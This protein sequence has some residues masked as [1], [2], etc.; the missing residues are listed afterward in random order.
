MISS[1]PN[2]PPASSLTDLVTHY[3][4][5]LSSSLTTLAPLKTRSVSFTHTAPWFTPHL[6]QLKAT[7]CRL[8][9]LYNKTQLTVHRQMY[10]DHLHHYK[11]AL[12]TA[13]TSYNSNLSQKAKTT[14]CQ[15]DPLPTSLV[16]ACL[17]SISPMITNI[18]N[19]SLTTGTVP[20]TLKLAAITPIL[21]KPGADPTDLNHYR[22]IS[23]L[24][25][26]SKTIERV[27]AAQLQ[28]HL[29][30][31]N[32]HEPFQSGFRPKHST[33]TA[34]VKITNDLFLAANSGLLTILILL[35]LSAAF[36]TISHP[37]LLD[38]LAGIGITGAE[39]SW[40]TSY[41]T[42][43]QQFLQLS[44]H[45]SGCSGVSLGVP[46]GSVLGP[47]LFTTYLL[48]L[49]TLL[50]HHGVHFHC[51]ADDTQVYI[52]TKPTA[53]I[54]PTSLITCLEEI[55]SWLSRNFLKLNGNKTE[56]LL[57]GSK[58]T[59]T[60]SQHTPAPL[61]IIDGSQYPSP[62]KSRASASSWTTPSHLHPIFTTS[63][64]LHSSTSATSPDSAHH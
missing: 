35:D 19:S 15:L 56:A 14:T 16:K 31:N 39:L 21:K 48:P 26:I 22:P 60:K 30:T 43:R 27:V 57:I 9:R 4:N 24:P 29:D 51:Y 58:S 54:P 13:K 37:L 23:N 61:I 59:L 6:R 5:C 38:R 10:S 32:L 28:S 63:P 34:L 12:T 1:Y 50:R 18:I 25:F 55:R 49:G 17:P 64:G 53:A 52:S 44:N 47:L 11:N 40:F 7:G 8:E 2:P 41:L 20:P 46:Q 42:G 62:P 36:N 3:N 33:E 45:K